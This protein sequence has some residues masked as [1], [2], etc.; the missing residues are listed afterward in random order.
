MRASEAAMVVLMAL[1][2]VSSLDAQRP[3]QEQS[4]ISASATGTVEVEADYA[5]LTL[6]V[7]SQDSTP[8]GAAEAMDSRLRSLTDTL[9]AMGFPAESLPTARY[10]INPERGRDR[11]Q[12][13]GYT[14]SGALRV[15]IWE[16]VRVPAV[17]EAALS[18]GATDV[19][20]LHFSAADVRE[21]R[22]EALGRA[23]AEASRDAEVLAAAACGRLG[24][25]IEISTSAPSAYGVRAAT[26]AETAR[27]AELS[28][29]ITPGAITVEA[30]VT[31]RWEIVKR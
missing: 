20:G 24:E 8:T 16:I 27:G 18:A 28:A 7:L 26:Y 30:T 1:S 6:G 31:A 13:S 19:T 15:N 4:V 10:R 21:A 3:E 25:A 17:I 29:G 14:A 11:S 5:V 2:I 22:D 23:Y 9:L 12:V